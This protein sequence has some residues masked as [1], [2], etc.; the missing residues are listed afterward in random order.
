MKTISIEYQ[1]KVAILK[2]DRS[3][4]NPLNLSLV[5]ELADILP[6]LEAD[7]DVRSL[8]LT[9]VRDKFFSIG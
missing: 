9:S 4:T 1:D 2:L 3:P 8:I 6:T 5:R 7:S